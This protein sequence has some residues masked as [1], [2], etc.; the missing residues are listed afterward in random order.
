MI[1]RVECDLKGDLLSFPIVFC[2]I[3]D[4]SAVLLASTTVMQL[5]DPCN[6]SL[7]RSSLFLTMKGASALLLVLTQKSVSVTWG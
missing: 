3:S 1:P 7:P 2:Y 5:I 6:F 4:C